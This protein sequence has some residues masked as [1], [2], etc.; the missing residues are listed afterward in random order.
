MQIDVYK[1]LPDYVRFT[2]ADGNALNE[3]LTPRQ[4]GLRCGSIIRIQEIDLGKDKQQCVPST[5]FVLA[6]VNIRM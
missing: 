4:L 5:P 6:V 1:R 2:D 3:F